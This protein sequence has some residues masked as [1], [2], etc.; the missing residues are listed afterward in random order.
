MKLTIHASKGLEFDSVYVAGL[1]GEGCSSALHLDRERRLAPIEEAPRL[2][3]VAM[4]RAR[5][6]VVL[7]HAAYR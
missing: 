4:T 3:Y 1:H 2:L 6:H 5:Q 7:T